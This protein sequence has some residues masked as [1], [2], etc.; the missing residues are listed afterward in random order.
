MPLDVVVFVSIL[1]LYVAFIPM[2]VMTKRHFD[3]SY[4][5]LMIMEIGGFVILILMALLYPHR[6]VDWDFMIF[7]ALCVVSPWFISLRDIWRQYR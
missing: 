6:A 1:F 3:Q 5:L 2:S 7:L 4:I